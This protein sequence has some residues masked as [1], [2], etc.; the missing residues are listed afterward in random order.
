MWWVS[1][2]FAAP[3]V[4]DALR[5]LCLVQVI[6]DSTLDLA[7]PGVPKVPPERRPCL[8]EETGPP[9]VGADG[10]RTFDDVRRTTAFDDRGRL[11]WWSALHNV[12]T[13]APG[14]P[15]RPLTVRSD[16]WAFVYDA[17]DRVIEVRESDPPEGIEQK[18]GLAERLVWTWTWEGDTLKQSLSGWTRTSRLAGGVPVR[19]ELPDG[20]AIE[21]RFGADGR[22]T[23]AVATLP[24]EPTRTTTLTRD[25]LGRLTEVRTEAGGEARTTR[26][27][28]DDRQRVVQIR[29][30]PPDAESVANL[31]YSC[32]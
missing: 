31:R 13:Q 7:C 23:G 29:S 21:Y 9:Q 2:A 5:Q 3:V 18:L 30:G 22:Q 32:P 20:G 17:Q 25:A 1:V 28:W 11:W 14:G 19:L 10:T 15:R 26:Y 16:T 8:I 6:T 24:G 12:A 27:T 4:D